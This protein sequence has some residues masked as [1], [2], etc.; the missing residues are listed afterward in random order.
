MTTETQEKKISKLVIMILSLFAVLLILQ[1]ASIF[2]LISHQKSQGLSPEA[3]LSSGRAD[4]AGWPAA[5]PVFRNRVTTPDWDQP[6]P[7]QSML[8][9]ANRMNSLFSQLSASSGGHTSDALEGFFDFSPSVDLQEKPDRYVVKVDLPG[10][11]K[12]QINITVRENLLT[13]QGVR[14]T[15]TQTEDDQR[16]YYAQERSYGTFARTIALPGP[17]EESAI[18]AN[19]QNG[20]LVIQLPKAQG[21]QATQ[22]VPVQ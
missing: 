21:E 8:Q 5:G 20:V 10:L 9:M 11:E 22:K 7:F 3:P 2:Y 4:N 15:E 1:T 18:Q 19:Y 16:G 14:K 6:D 12:D 17:V 13:I